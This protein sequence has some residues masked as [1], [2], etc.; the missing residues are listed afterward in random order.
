MR[1][2]RLGPSPIP[3]AREFCLSASVCSGLPIFCLEGPVLSDLPRESNILKWLDRA[4]REF[5][6]EK[7]AGGF[8]R[9][10]FSRRASSLSHASA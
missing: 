5:E 6:P 7:E 2:V 8:S 9:P 10:G 1:P 3:V 4:A